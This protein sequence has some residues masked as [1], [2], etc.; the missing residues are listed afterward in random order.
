MALN[1]F[2]H[3]KEIGRIINVGNRQSVNRIASQGWF[4]SEAGAYLPD[5]A[6]TGSLD[7]HMNLHNVKH[8]NSA[9]GV[10]KIKF[11]EANINLTGNALECLLIEENTITIRGEGKNKGK[12]NYGFLVTAIDASSSGDQIKIT[13][14]DKL[15]GD[16]VIYDNLV[17]NELGGGYITIIPTPFVKEGDELNIPYE[18]SLEQNYPNPFN[19]STTIKYSIPD[20]GF[21]TLKVYDIIGN[22]LITLVNEERSPGSYEVSF[23]A[24]E[25]S[26]GIYIYS[27]RTDGF[28][29]TK[30][31]MLIK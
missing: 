5:P 13:I 25:Y 2:L 23:N 3:P 9:K 12:G 20:N 4:N 28:T 7:F 29:Q 30:K 1:N 8:P 24:S 6:I 16:K 19:P 31:M 21:V 22:E 17:M 27:L 18:F 14:W 10:V 15:D 11:P 26:S